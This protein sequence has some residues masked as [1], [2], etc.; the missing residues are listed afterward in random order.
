MRVLA[1]L[2]LFAVTTAHAAPDPH[3]YANSDAVRVEHAHLD[4]SVSFEQR[5]LSGFVELRLKRLD[6]AADRLMLDTRDLSIDSVLAISGD[7][8]HATAFKLAPRD[9]VFGSALTI[10]LPAA[11]DRVRIHYH[12]APEA[13][14]LQWLEPALT[15]GKRLPFMFSQSQAIHA[16]S[17]VPIQDSPAVRFTYSARISTP[18]GLLARMSAD[19]NPRDGADGDYR[20]TMR[21]P[22]PSGCGPWPARSASS[23]PAAAAI[24]WAPR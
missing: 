6:P 12:T 1:A 4:L 14:G 17:W 10:E 11:A 3:S 16:R 7:E 20:F 19:N 18:A 8:F 5:Q 21:R 15:A 22:I 24:T 9:P 23:S 2:A 13:S